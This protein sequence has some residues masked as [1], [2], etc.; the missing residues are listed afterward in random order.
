M[1]GGYERGLSQ[2]T[3]EGIYDRCVAEGNLQVL[4]DADS[5]LAKSLLS[6]A[7]QDLDTLRDMGPVIEKKGSFSL[8]WSS[9][10]HIIR[11]LVQA[12]MLLELVKP[13]NDQCMF[14]YVCIKHDDWDIDWESLETMRV[15]RNRII[16]EATPVSADTWRSY[17]LKFDLYTQTFLRIL[18]D[19]MK[20][21]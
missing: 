8:L 9:R 1:T 18:R 10:Y 14:A 7:E 20:E 16:D 5:T 15:V 6:M 3:L 2:S 21:K 12:I 19:Q 13:G 17:R 4:D 11:Q